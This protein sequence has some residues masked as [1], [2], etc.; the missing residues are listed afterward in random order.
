[1]N[2]F[3]PCLPATNSRTCDSHPSLSG[4]GAPFDDSPDWLSLDK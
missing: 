1:V 4:A 2:P 3:N